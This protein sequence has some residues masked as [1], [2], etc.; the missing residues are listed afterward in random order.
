[1]P[2]MDVNANVDRD[3][4]TNTNEDYVKRIYSSYTKIKDWLALNG[5]PCDLR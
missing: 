3:T 4:N 1:M 2:I 5:M